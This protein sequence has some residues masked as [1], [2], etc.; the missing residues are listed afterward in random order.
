LQPRNEK[1]NILIP[2]KKRSA[3]FSFHPS[4]SSD[5]SKHNDEDGEREVK[6]IKFQS[7]QA[8]SKGKTS[9]YQ[10]MKPNNRDIFEIVKKNLY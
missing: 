3:S 1:S 8:V 5:P 6:K 2:E 9:I 7:N 10:K 4:T